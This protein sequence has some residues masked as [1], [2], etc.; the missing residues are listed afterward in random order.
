MSP[1]LFTTLY[2][3]SKTMKKFQENFLKIENE[4]LDD[5]CETGDDYE[6]DPEQKL[7]YLH[8]LFYNEAEKLRRNH[9]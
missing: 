3:Y 6:L 8:R 7:R 2:L 9:V 5:Y 1:N 4:Y